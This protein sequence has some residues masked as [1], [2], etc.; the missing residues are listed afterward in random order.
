MF[1]DVE[2]KLKR[3]N[4]VLFNRDS[5]CLE[6][7]I[8]LIKR[9]KHRTLVLWAFECVKSPLKI[10]EE[11]YPDEK[12]PRKA[13]ELCKMWASGEIKMPEAKKAILDCH[14]VCKEIDDE[15]YIALCHG[16]AQGISTVHVETHALGLP[17][18]ELTSIVIK[19]RDNYEEKV[20]EK[21]K[22][23]IDTLTYFQNN[24]DKINNKWAK[25]LLN[26]KV[27]NKEKLLW[28]KKKESNI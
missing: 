14:A 11:K 6:D 19:N 18:Y 17:F 3:K 26:D 22:Y 20:K 13:I 10:F 12:R 2:E 27:P 25:F 15:Y 5:K 7:L 1:K 24:V 9:Q 23:Y 16:I 4:K 28:E 8:E 21:I